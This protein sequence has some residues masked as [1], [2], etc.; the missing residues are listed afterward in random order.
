MSWKK[1]KFSY[2]MWFLYTLFSVAVLMLAT[3]A[4]AEK[5]FGKIPLG[6]LIPG[7]AIAVLTGAA[8]Y[9]RQWFIE[10]R[11]NKTEEDT[12]SSENTVQSSVG[13]RSRMVWEI[14]AVMALLILGLILRLDRMLDGKG[15]LFA[16]YETAK[17]AEGQVIPS[18]VHG[19]D[20]LYL[21]VLHLL[22]L[23][24]GNKFVA[25]VWL[26]ILTQLLASLILFV[27][28]RRLAGPA[29]SLVMLG[30]FMFAGTMID[31]AVTLSPQMLYL[32]FFAIGIN[33]LAACQKCRLSHLAFL[34]AGIWTGLMGYLDIGGFLLLILLVSCATGD[35]NM[36]TD[37]G[38]K[39]GALCFGLIGSLVGF[40]GAIGADTFISDKAFGNVLNAWLG[41]YYP[42][43]FQS[44]VLL[45]H[46]STGWWTVVL[47][48]F[49]IAGVFGFWYDKE[50]DRMSMW[51]LGGCVSIVA[52]CFGMF[53]EELPMD[54]YLFLF[55]VV[56]AGLGVGEIYNEPVEN[57][58][59]VMEAEAPEESEMAKKEK[60]EKRKKNRKEEME[61][62]VV[63]TQETQASVETV[64]LSVK[65]PKYLREAGTGQVKIPAYMLPEEAP[66]APEP[67][68][69]I[70]DEEPDNTPLVEAMPQ[71][72][73]A[74]V[75]TAELM[76][77]ETPAEMPTAEWAPEEEPAEVTAAQEPP[78]ETPTEE[79]VAEE[80]PE[81][82]HTSTF[83]RLGETTLPT[84]V[85]NLKEEEKEE[86]KEE[87]TGREIPVADE[88]GHNEPVA[89]GSEGES[90][91]EPEG[92]EPKSPKYIENPLPLPKPHVKRIMDYARKTTPGEDDF[93][94]PVSEDD[95][96]DI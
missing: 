7:F 95:D 86:E 80:M 43:D 75:P 33:I 50:R 77:E 51:V 14:V 6:G 52:G 53:T 35:R 17:V 56:L 31:G 83:R 66:K 3:Q 39:L 69:A 26:Q 44:S 89:S 4:Q 30:F 45:N 42:G 67:V 61:A 85:P 55:L 28:V 70:A 88:Q 40:L 72:E 92:E 41:L 65:L 68:K 18:V 49:M 59:E 74:E 54:L 22:F 25:G 93:D 2:F 63:Q 21:N 91:D 94:H 29:A 57:E 20:Y 96:F 58:I 32:F 1:N 34:G 64:P 16:Y 15:D 8:V 81:K 78:A 48:V 38:K 84:A 19:A 13:S 9:L 73:P 11:K 76:P 37:R 23:F 36:K 60:K 62:A 90:T 82:E 79:P 27:G 47:T 24:V 12:F 10:C 87:D 5:L 46:V 71:E